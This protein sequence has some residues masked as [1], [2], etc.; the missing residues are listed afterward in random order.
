MPRPQPAWQECVV[1]CL[2]RPWFSN[3]A[4][5][6]E[7]R[8]IVR[9]P[10]LGPRHFGRRFPCSGNRA[11]PTFPSFPHELEW[12]AACRLRLQEHRFVLDPVGAKDEVG[13]RSVG[14][15]RLPRPVCVRS[16]TAVD[17]SAKRSCRPRGEVDERPSPCRRRA[18]PFGSVD[19]A[20][21][22][23][24]EI[25]GEFPCMFQKRIGFDIGHLELR[26]SGAPASTTETIDA[27]A[28][29]R[30]PPIVLPPTTRNT[31][32][33]KKSPGLRQ[34]EPGESG[35]SLTIL[36]QLLRCDPSSIRM[37]WNMLMKS[38]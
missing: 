22:A 35:R 24:H 9:S 18:R 34:G 29:T 4:A 26:R 27:T 37:A 38:R 2:V 10:S 31:V 23:A 20:L 7:R 36:C 6:F 14:G 11:S 25:V 28:P 13:E 17:I 3:L 8:A 15:D 1:L 12:R 33:T 16:T 19:K 32:Q 21:A 30:S 5:P